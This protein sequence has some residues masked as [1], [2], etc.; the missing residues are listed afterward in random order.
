MVWIIGA[1]AV[2]FLLIIFLI[3][4]QFAHAINEITKAVKQ[5]EKGDYDIKLNINLSSE[6]RKLSTAL[7]HLAKHLDQSQIST[8][9]EIQKRTGQIT[10]MNQFMVNRELKMIELKK[11]IAELKKQKRS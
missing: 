6:L 8:E 10:K 4:K 2:I 11:E 5:L 9:V 3:N 7:N 1:V